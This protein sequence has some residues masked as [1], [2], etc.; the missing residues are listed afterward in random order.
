MSAIFMALG[1]LCNELFID[2]ATADH[3]T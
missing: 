2:K 1:P 3:G